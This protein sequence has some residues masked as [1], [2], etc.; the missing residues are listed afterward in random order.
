MKN[1]SAKVISHIDLYLGFEDEKLDNL[2]ISPSTS[3]MNKRFPEP[4][5]SVK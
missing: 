2:D 3:H 1:G 4:I 5:A